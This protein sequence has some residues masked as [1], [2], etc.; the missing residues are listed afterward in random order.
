MK[1]QYLMILLLISVMTF[2]SVN[3][4]AANTGAEP[5]MDAG[6]WAERIVL[7]DQGLLQKGDRGHHSGI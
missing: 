6:K 2:A 7:G 4:Y 5:F 3:V 1:K